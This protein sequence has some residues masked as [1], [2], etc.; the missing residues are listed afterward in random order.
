MPEPII[1]KYPL[2]IF[3]YPYTDRSEAAQQARAEQYCPFLKGECKKPRKSEPHVKVGICTVGYKG[4]FSDRFLPVI[5]CP[6]RLDTP[7]IFEVIKTDYFGVLADDEKVAWAPEVSLGEA[8]SVDYVAV[9]MKKDE[10]I[11]ATNDFVCVEL[12]AAG[13]TGTP[14]QAILE[15]RQTG[16]FQSNTYN[17]GI[18]WANE[19]LKTMMQQVYKKG[20]I[21]ESWG[22]RIIFVIQDVGLAYLQRACDTSGLRDAARE[23]PIHFYTFKMNWVDETNSW[24]LNLDKKVS[25][26][27]EGIRRILAGADKNTYPTIDKFMK[28]VT[29]K[30]N[31][32]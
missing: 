19:F 1:K 14:W 16:Q 10:N 9:K 24:T 15:Y 22:K 6:H 27:T 23:D 13:T 8:G 32:K 5:I 4:D 17:Y 26:D 30:P 2:E 18:N 29:R 31:H 21:I 7:T 20:A 11:D 28:S 3:G 25:T 12:Q